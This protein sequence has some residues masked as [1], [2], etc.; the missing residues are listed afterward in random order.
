MCLMIFRLFRSTSPASWHS[1]AG[2]PRFGGAIDCAIDENGR[3]GRDGGMRGI[4]SGCG[5]EA[6]IVIENLRDGDDA[7]GDETK[8]VDEASLMANDSLTW[9]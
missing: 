2:L 4:S 9:R 7:R 1:T 5:L 8:D 3:S 6:G